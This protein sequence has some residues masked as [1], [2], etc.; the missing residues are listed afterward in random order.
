MR[1]KGAYRERGVFLNSVR[2]IAGELGSQVR[3][4]KWTS[5]GALEVDVFPP[6]AS[7]FEIL[8][9][10]LQPL[11]PVEFYRDLGKA[12]PHRTRR[13]TFSEARSLF[14]A[15]R[16]WEC[17]EVLE[18]AWRNMQGDEKSF[19]QGVILLC[20]AFVHHQKGEETVA[21]GVL[22][23]AVKQLSF[24]G[25]SLEGFDAEKLRGRSESIMSD[26]KFV[27]FEI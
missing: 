4:P 9:A 8:L 7:D 27:P 3:N 16:Y 5:Y 18:E 24:P 1:V 10:A 14:N 15:E 22:A 12:P 11:G 26:G 2:S 23:R 6:S 13:E 21:L 19:T 17:H 25:G 20:A